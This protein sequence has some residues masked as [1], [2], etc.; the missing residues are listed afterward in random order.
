MTQTSTTETSNSQTDRHDV[1][2]GQIRRLR[3]CRVPLIVV[4][5]LVS[6]SAVRVAVGYFGQ[7][8]PR[9]ADRSEL[10]EPVPQASATP[11]DETS[12][13][14]SVADLD[15]PLVGEIAS[16]TDVLP[17]N[18]SNQDADEPEPQAV[19]A[20]DDSGILE[21]VEYAVENYRYSVESRLTS[22]Y[23]GLQDTA[24]SSWSNAG[25]RVADLLETLAM[26]DNR[27]ASQAVDNEGVGHPGQEISEDV[28][29]VLL[30]P[31][32]TGGAVHYLVNGQV[33]SLRP[34]ET[35]N[36]GSGDT[37]YIQFHR[38]EDFG[39]AGYT[40]DSGT[41]AYQ[42]TEDGWDLQ[43]VSLSDLP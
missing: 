28:D 13:G 26:A 1:W 30:N 18:G 3:F 38:G 25:E 40:L 43:V 6:A 32:E 42:V 37:F 21:G 33:H 36:L 39:N 10:S 22:V 11:E 17:D 35:H 23:A 24:E 4:L 34:G 31:G 9:T 27:A 12:T 7:P 8:S 29:T 41:Y 15:S 20:T 5:L 14:E 19:A 16:D 2:S